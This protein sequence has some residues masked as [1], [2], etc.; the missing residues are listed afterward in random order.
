MIYGVDIGG[1]K[2]EFACF[3]AD[4]NKLES[5]R[6]ATP[7]DDYEM[8]IDTLAG[9]VENA[10]R[11]HRCKGKVGIGMPGL[12]DAEGRS[13]SANIACA[14]GKK[15]AESLAARLGHTIVIENDCRLFALSE[16]RGGAGQGSRHVYGAV[17]GTGAAGGLVIEGR[18]YR[19]RQGI[20]GEYG[21]HPLPAD[22]RKKYQ[23]P[24]LRCGCGLLGCLE[25][26]ITGPGLA[27]LHR[28][29]W[30]EEIEIPA[31]V[32]RWRDGDPRALNTKAVHLD[33]LGAAFA[34]LVMAHDP[35]IFVLGGGLSRIQEFYRDLPG[36]IENQLFPGFSAPPVVPP[37][38]GDA[39]GARG[40][41]LLALTSAPEQKI[42]TDEN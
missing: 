17:L 4:L 26:Y 33:L 40:A 22:L 5:E 24:L 16:S 41:A 11:R 7:V 35:D 42:A 9:L 39:S 18:L 37:K 30:G 29:L 19:G 25:T 1:T 3:D 12:I 13:L 36:A 2:I 23:L 21:H 32:Q 38:F 34:N 28:Q 20:A 6:L 27:T 15:V 14:N 8:F 31:L 10:D